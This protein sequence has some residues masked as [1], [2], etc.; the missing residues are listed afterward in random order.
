[1]ILRGAVSQTSSEYGF[2]GVVVQKSTLRIL[3]HEGMFWDHTVNREFYENALRAYQEV[4]YLEFTNFDNLFGKV[5]TTG[6]P[7]ISNNPADDP[8]SGGL[9][10]GHPP[11]RKFLG[12]PILKG[13]EVVGMIGL[14]NRPGGYTGIEQ[15]KIEILMQAASVIYD[16][17]RRQKREEVLERKRM[18]TEEALQENQRKLATLLSN[19]PGYSYRCKNDKDWTLDFISDG[20]FELT[21]YTVDEY[22]VYRTITCAEK[23]HPDDRDRVWAEVQAALEK[24]QQFELVYRVITKSNDVIWVWERGQ[25]IYSSDGD[26]LYIDGFVTDITDLVKAEADR[27][28]LLDDLEAKHEQLQTLSRRL[29]EIQESERSH[30][31]RELHDEIGQILTGLKS[32][33]LNRARFYRLT[34]LERSSEAWRS[35]SMS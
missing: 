1:M 35:W 11:L 33:R 8:R 17:Y 9:P 5:I 25:G 24:R 32:S 12:V 7:V 31:A 10:M 29:V 4:G 6:K 19:L 23:T 30:I 27:E 3:A 20:V 34:R 14:A 22:L 28:R 15:S 26:L 2:I 18:L 16:S 21:G 13:A